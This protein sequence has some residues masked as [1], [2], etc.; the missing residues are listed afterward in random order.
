LARQTLVAVRLGRDH[1]ADRGDFKQSGRGLHDQGLHD[2]GRNER[3][4]VFDDPHVVQI[5][6][7]N[8][9]GIF[10]GDGPRL[11][12]AQVFRKKIHEFREFVFE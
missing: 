12:G 8:G 11:A 9:D 4:L 5:R 6:I 1:A 3:R 2:R 10:V 7:V